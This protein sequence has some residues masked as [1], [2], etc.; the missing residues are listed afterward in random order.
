MN[1]EYQPGGST[2]LE[3]LLTRED[4]AQIL[5]CSTR[6]VD[7][8]VASG[9]LPAI[10]IGKLVRFRPGQIRRLLDGQSSEATK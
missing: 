5:C 4:L 8:L 2:E 7:R 9:D 6:T 1:A 10:R 3:E